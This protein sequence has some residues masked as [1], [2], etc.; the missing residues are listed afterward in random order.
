MLMREN[1]YDK[2]PHT[3]AGPIES[4]LPG[5]YYLVQIDEQHR[6]TYARA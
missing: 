1:A 3:P 2:S 4:L 6:R 5:T